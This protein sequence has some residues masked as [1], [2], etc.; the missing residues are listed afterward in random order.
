MDRNT[1]TVILRFFCTTGVTLETQEF[2]PKAYFT[3]IPTYSYLPLFMGSSNMQ[4]HW[5]LDL[6]CFSGGR[7]CGFFPPLLRFG[8]ECPDLPPFVLHLRTAFFEAHLLSPSKIWQ[9]W[10]LKS[11][12]FWWKPPIALLH[13]KSWLLRNCSKFSFII[14]LHSYRVAKTHRL[15]YQYWPFSAKEPSN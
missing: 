7:I 5:D 1:E 6:F 4:E 13:P 2:F 8:A 12:R 11:Y 14:M 9:L 10:T 3:H 15:P